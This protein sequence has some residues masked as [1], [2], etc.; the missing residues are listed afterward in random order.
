MLG[1]LTILR[2][3]QPL[4]SAGKAQ[5]KPLELL[6][7]LA[8]HGGR[9]VD[10][11]F[12]IDALWPSLEADAPKASLEMAVSRLRKLLDL[13][14]AVSVVD[15]A[16]SLDPSLVWCDA[17][18]FEALAELLQSGLAE[19]QPEAQLARTAERAFAL[20]RDRLLGSEELAGPM[21]LA[22]ERLALCF[23]R[24]VTSWG[25]ALEA[26][27]QWSDAIVL[28]ER[29]LT[30]EV[31]AEPIYRALMRAQLARGERAEALRTFR[32]CRELLA[33]VLGTTPAAETLALFHEASA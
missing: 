19:R 26:G 32:R 25:G 18:A 16:V 12:I 31:L 14:E 8:A 9:P 6:A 5:R 17:T 10:A 4:R 15:G 3:D 21:R 2:D 13:P 28:Y 1:E 11:D 33:S 30:R 29:A 27:G 23:Y 20:Y 24:A 7:L 22:R